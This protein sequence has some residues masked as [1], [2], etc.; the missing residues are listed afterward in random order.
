MYRLQEHA[1]ETIE[2]LQTA[3]MKVW[4]L[5]GDKMETAK[6]TCYASRL[7]QTNTELLELTTKTLGDSDRKEDRLHELLLEYHKKLLP[8]FPKN[9]GKLKRCERACGPFVWITALGE[10]A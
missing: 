8:D 2:A 3:G 9:S 5:T 1:A 4:V 10:D 6:S 7:F